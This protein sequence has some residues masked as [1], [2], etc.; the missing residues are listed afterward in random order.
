MKRFLCVVMA[1]LLFCACALA[2]EKAVPGA[3]EVAL[4]LQYENGDG[5]EQDYAKAMEYYLSAAEAGNG[6]GMRRVGRLYQYGNGVESD[7]ALAMEWYVRGAEAGDTGSIRNIGYF[8]ENGFGVEQDYAVAMEWYLKAAEADEPKAMND[9]GYLYEN[10]LG[11]EQNYSLAMEWYLKAAETGNADA[12]CYVGWLYSFGLG[13]EQDDTLALAWYLRAAEA[14]SADGMFNAGVYY[15]LGQGAEQEFSLAAEWFLKAAEAGHPSAMSNIGASYANGE[16][17]EQDAGKAAEWFRKSAEAGDAR[18]MCIYAQ[19]L[20]NGEGVD[21]D[22]EAAAEWYQK[23]GE[24]G[25]PEAMYLYAQMLGNSEDM[26]KYAATAAQWYL[27][28]AEDGIPEFMY[29]YAQ[30]LENG[31]GV[32]KN[33]E[34]AQEWYDKAEAAGYTLPAFALSETEKTDPDSLLES[35]TTEQKIAQLIMPAFYYYTND[36]GKTVGM[37]E[38]HPDVEALLREYGFSGVIFNLQNAKDNEKAARLVDAMQTANAS[39][40][41]RPQL[42]TFTDQEGGYVT[43]LGQGTQMPGNMALGAADDPAVTESAG[44]LIGQEVTAIG[45]SGAFAPVLDVNS[46]PANPV[47]GIR[48]FS[49]DPET[50]AQQGVA[51]MN[52]LRKAG[53]LSA[54]KHF[55]GHGDTGTDSH[56]GLPCVNK[57]YEELKAFELIPF[58]AAIDAGADMVMTAHIVYPQV[59]MGTY[60]S[61]KTG[62]EIGLPATLSKTILTDILRG[63]MGFEGLI[64]S[65]A[66]NMDAIATHF[67]PLD[68]ARLAIEAGVD[69]ILLPV[70]TSSPEGL[71]ALKQYIQ[72]VASMAD[73]GTL[74]MEAVDAA[75]LRVLSFKEKHGLLTP[76]VC[77]DLEAKV[78]QAVTTVG[79]AAHHETEFEIAKEAVTL[80]KNE[81]VFP[82]N[83][84]ESVAVLVPYSSELM[85]AEYAVQRL[86]DEGTLPE[87]APV[88][89]LYLG[90]MTVNDLVNTAQKTKHLIVI[91]AAYSLNGMNPAKTNG[92]DSVIVEAL[93]TLAHAAGNDVTVISAQLPYDAARFPDADAVI[94]AYGAR[95]MS[96]DPR[97]KEYGVSQYGPNLPAAIYMALSGQPMTGKLPVHIPALNENCE[98]T[99]EILYPRGYSAALTELSEKLKAFYD[100]LVDGWDF[101]NE[102]G[103]A[104]EYDGGFLKAELT[105][106]AI[107]I[108]ETPE[109]REPLTW[110]FV[111]EGDWLTAPLG[112]DEAEGRSMAYWLLNDAISAQGVNVDLFLGYINALTELQSKYLKYDESDGEKKVSVNIAGS[113]EYDLDAMDALAISEEHLLAEGWKPVSEDYEMISLPYGKVYVFG[114]ATK[115]GVYVTISEYGGLDDLA[116]QAI[117][118]FVKVLQP[119]GWENF[120]AEYTEL[121]DAETA[122]FT[123]KVN[124]D[125]AGMEDTWMKYQEGYGFANFIIGDNLLDE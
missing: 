84:K 117:V 51:L 19:M 35:M 8:Y 67:D 4:G 115:D 24:A 121:K 110:T 57:T 22:L 74:S 123:A 66:M 11:V 59:E 73:S 96:E 52:G 17:V 21:K 23:S 104:A 48:S 113:Y 46:N 36:E 75:V 95:G 61:K 44:F 118:S 39:V 12:M 106:N 99:D 78:Q 18:G 92:S 81:G 64:V 102:E 97:N 16:G 10:G 25:H 87:N 124:L 32:E 31:V 68:A 5:V 38:L 120:I 26:E 77:E 43:R 62:E 105:D 30:M 28:C 13:V 3:E 94:V 60:T 41:G 91:H 116:F 86:K 111:Q 100:F 50:V 69:L 90:N 9:I 49:D 70:D 89:V 114:A 79:S 2:E 45:Y 47:I 112:P 108:T 40:P 1:M 7:Y 29:R 55:P 72:D 14:G 27:Q 53:A 58:Q 6:E 63:D 107:V 76:Y 101:L 20:E 82:L 15:Y 80:V 33:E 122:D 85:S 37:E 83:P 42:L 125:E 109:D 71:A 98:Y 103:T 54:L 88:S 93:L 65:D 56:T 34:L 119:K